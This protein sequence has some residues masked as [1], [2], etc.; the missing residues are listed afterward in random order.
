MA[1]AIKLDQ[2]VLINLSDSQRKQECFAAVSDILTRYQCVLDP[3]VVIS[4]GGTEL[5]VDIRTIPK[6]IEVNKDN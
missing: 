6:P 2:A 4:T 5:R 3:V 1:K